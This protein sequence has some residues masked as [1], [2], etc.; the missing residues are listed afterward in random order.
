VL[1][2]FPERLRGDIVLRI[3]SLDGIQPN[4]LEELDDILERQ[5]AG[6]ANVQS[7]A[8]GGIKAAA[9][10]LN[11]CE[12]SV[13]SR[14]MEQ[15]LAQDQD[16]AQKIQDNMFVFDNLTAVDDRSIQT[17][18]REIASDQLLLALRGADDELKA[19]I[20]KNMSKRAA[21]MLRE[22][23]AAAAP[24][25][26]ADVEAAQKE[27]LAVARRLSDAGEMALGGAG[28]EAYV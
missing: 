22:D 16:L 25:R 8:L 18:L 20:F 12:G 10:I 9:S 19:K 5:F 26:L 13:E 6:S 15:I 27:I 24:A 4:A 7:S 1:A 11:L 14:V 28:G 21:E 2:E 17:L 23:L 3:A